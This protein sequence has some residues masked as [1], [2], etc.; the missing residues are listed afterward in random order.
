MKL[1]AYIKQ[2]STQEARENFARQCGTSLGHLRNVAYGYRP[3][4]AELAV[5]IEQVTD[6]AVTR[7]ELCPS[8]WHRIWPELSTNCPA[9]AEQGA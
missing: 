8:N 5:C 6:G 9:T 4:A 7:Q 2:L 3:C 1:S